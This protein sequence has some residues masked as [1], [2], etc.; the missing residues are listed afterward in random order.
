[1][2]DQCGE[3]EVE[4]IVLPNCYI[5]YYRDFPERYNITKHTRGDCAFWQELKKTGKATNDKNKK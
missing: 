5:N 3:C 1:M 2:L 4:T